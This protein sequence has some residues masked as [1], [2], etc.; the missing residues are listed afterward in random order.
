[1][2]AMTGRC[3]CGQITW[4]SEGPVLWA[5][6]CHCD[7]C[8]RASSAPFTSFF[9]VPRTGVIW[10]GDVAFRASSDAVERGHC[11][12]CGAQVSYKST[13]W[14]EEIHLYAATLDDPSMFEPKA[15]FHWAERVPWI[16]VSDRLAKYA[17]SA[18]NA[19]PV[20]ER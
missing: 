15:H 10:Q 8:R 3:A 20:E 16:A 7:S 17:G 18:E 6:H 14:P 19:L 11:P 4:K 13:K 2:A 1:M 5:G 12:T 9:G